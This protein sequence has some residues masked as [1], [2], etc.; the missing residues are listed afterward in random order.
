LPP[1][2][3][4]RTGEEKKR[5]VPVGNSS[6]AINILMYRRQKTLS[7]ESCICV[8]SSLIMSND[9]VRVEGGGRREE[10]GGRRGENE[11]AGWRVEGGRWKNKGTFLVPYGQ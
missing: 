2:K 11:E 6:K 3:F 10:G 5:N 8:C 9:L 1:G 4:L 7:K